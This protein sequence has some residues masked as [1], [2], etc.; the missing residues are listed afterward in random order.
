MDTMGIPARKRRPLSSRSLPSD[1]PC[2]RSPIHSDRPN[3]GCAIRYARRTTGRRTSRRDMGGSTI[4]PVSL[5]RG[6]ADSSVHHPV[7]AAAR[8]ALPAIPPPRPLSRAL[9]LAP[10]GR[11]HQTRPLPPAIP[12]LAD[13][14]LVR[15]RTQHGFPAIPAAIPEESVPARRRR[16]RRTSPLPDHLRRG[17][18]CCK[19]HCLNSSCASTPTARVQ[20]QLAASVR[21]A[22]PYTDG[23][24][25]VR[26]YD[27]NSADR[28]SA[29]PDRGFI[30]FAKTKA[31]RTKRRSRLSLETV[32]TITRLLCGGKRRRQARH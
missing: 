17:E 24:H 13:G 28:A 27:G 7:K 20:R 5:R 1:E 3:W 32:R 11:G 31:E 12:T 14:T 15:T 9:S 16:S 19:A 10:R 30:P 22:R 8:C 21:A 26:P 29:R 2:P 23:T 6:P 4:S 25:D 18:D